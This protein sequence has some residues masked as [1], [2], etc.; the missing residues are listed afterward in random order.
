VKISAY[1]YSIYG[2][3]P[4]VI[5]NISPDTLREDKK[6]EDDTYYRV[7]VR[8]ETASLT[9]NGQTLAIM[10]GMTATVEIRTG[11]KTV[12]DYLLKPVFKVREALRER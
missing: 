1:D 3:L 5:E 7:L 8:T 4:G 10:P 6:S 12:M 9:S 11:E 2:T